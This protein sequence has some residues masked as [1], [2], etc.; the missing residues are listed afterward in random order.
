MDDAFFVRRGEAEGHMP[1]VLERLRQRQSAGVDQRAQRAPVEHLRDD[2]RRRA[3]AADVEDLED[4]RVT[5]RG[6]GACLLLEAAEPIGIVRECRRQDLDGDIAGEARVVSA[7]HFPHPA[8]ADRY[9]FWS[10]P[11]FEGR[12]KDHSVTLDARP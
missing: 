12:D 2:V 11:S 7:I 6:G 1:R 8:A 3:V 4:V 10:G 9:P 5:E